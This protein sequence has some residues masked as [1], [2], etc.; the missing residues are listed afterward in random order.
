MKKIFLFL[1]IIGSLYSCKKDALS[2]RYQEF[3]GTWEFE[4]YSGYPFTSTPLPPGNGQIIYIGSDKTFERRSF[5]TVL[6]RAKYIL[7]E[8][9]DCYDEDKKL[10]FKSTES[11][12]SESKISIENGKLYLTSSNCLSDVGIGIYRRK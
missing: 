11:N 9:K 3:A 4:Q 10:F 5:D 6:V 2:D 8:R 12:S 7:E 1:L